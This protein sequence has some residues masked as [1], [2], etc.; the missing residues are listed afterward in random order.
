V[1][2]ARDAAEAQARRAEAQ[3]RAT[4]ARAEQALAAAVDKLVPAATAALGEAV[5]L[6]ERRRDRRITLGWLGAGA[7]VA[8][9]LFGGGY[10][11]RASADRPALDFHARC[12]AA[13]VRA[14]ASGRLYCPVDATSGQARPQQQ[15]R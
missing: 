11:T 10:A 9:A 5:V 13:A 12:L 2:A 4:A 6:R 1:N 3:E 14:E 15:R 8:L 7:A